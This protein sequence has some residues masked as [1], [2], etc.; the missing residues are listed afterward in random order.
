MPPP[1]EVL[2]PVYA[3]WLDAVLGRPLPPERRATCADC[4]MCP[5]PDGQPPASVVAFRPDVKCCTFTPELPNF[6][7]GGILRDEAA[8]LSPDEAH[9]RRTLEA[10]LEEGHGVSPLGLYRAPERDH[11]HRTMG[12]QMGR[13]RA[14]LC[15]HYV[16]ERGTCGIHRWREAVCATYFCKHERAA[17]GLDA[18][19]ELRELLFMT[20]SK[21]ALWCCLELGLDLPQLRP[22]LG[23]RPSEPADPPDAAARAARWGRWAG[24]EREF[25][26]ACAERVLPLTWDEV[27]AIGGV[28]VEVLAR[29]TRAAWARLEAPLPGRVRLGTW[30]VVAAGPDGVRIVTH[31]GYD[32]LDLPHALLGVLHLFEG[33]PLSEAR[34]ELAAR[35][36]ALEDDAVGRLLDW[37][38]LHPLEA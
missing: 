35:G 14:H 34:A 23:P 12:E 24:R 8:T 29:S 17:R 30:Q 26:R 33:R 6:L 10:R 18:W 7:V 19:A 38:V 15:P 5:G 32:P 3:R 2:P 31:S 11:L 13:S 28:E 37:G 16:R 1:P 25:Y 4:V 22:L 27:A 21:L 36:L 20:Q 9:G